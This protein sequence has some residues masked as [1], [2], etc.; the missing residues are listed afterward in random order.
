MDEPD[1]AATSSVTLASAIAS[2]DGTTPVP[3]DDLFMG[4]TGFN[5]GYGTLLDSVQAELD[6]DQCE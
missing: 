3:M 4:D 2:T 5:V 1:R 6:V